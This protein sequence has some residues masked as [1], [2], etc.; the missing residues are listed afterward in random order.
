VRVDHDSFPSDVEALLQAIDGVLREG[1][2]RPT[3]VA[4]LRG[5]NGKKIAGAAV[6]VIALA[7]TIALGAFIS[8]GSSD[9]A[10]A[11]S[12]TATA[13]PLSTHPAAS[14]QAQTGSG[15]AQQ[16]ADSNSKSQVPEVTGQSVSAAQQILNAA[17]YTN[18]QAKGVTGSSQPSGTVV[19]QKPTA[20]SNADPSLTITLDV[21]TGG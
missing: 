9:H 13:P 18:I 2:D 10:S 21:E 7:I 3:M 14:T 8:N 19:D 4:G 15:V 16:V 11:T 12:S 1:S 17:G 5:T 6:A 20:G